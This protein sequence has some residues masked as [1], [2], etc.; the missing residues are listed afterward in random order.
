MVELRPSREISLG[1]G[2]GSLFGGIPGAAIMFLTGHTGIG[3][4]MQTSA[5]LGGMLLL[6]F[7]KPVADMYWLEGDE[8][9]TAEQWPGEHP[10]AGDAEPGTRLEFRCAASTPNQL[11]VVIPDRDDPRCNDIR[12][13]TRA[14]REEYERRK[15]VVLALHR[16]QRA[17]R[18][19]AAS[20]PGGTI[21]QI[22]ANLS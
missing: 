3:L 17:A 8:E 9:A 12:P 15:Q 6:K 11:W 20:C 13:A 10:A 21:P 2:L 19:T 14:E 22:D 5:L 7:G 16:A 1:L 4:L 18:N